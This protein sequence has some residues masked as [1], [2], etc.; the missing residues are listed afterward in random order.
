MYS[1]DVTSQ[2]HQSPSRHRFFPSQTPVSRILHAPWPVAPRSDPTLLN[3]VLA[4]VH[5]RDTHQLNHL[6]F[7][8][9]NQ[10]ECLELYPVS[11]VTMVGLSWGHNNPIK[12]CSRF[13]L[14][15]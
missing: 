7:T 8:T 14:G 13:V 11:A 2:F 12:S 5:T 4:P 6:C 1:L 9:L 10:P 15:Q 3:H